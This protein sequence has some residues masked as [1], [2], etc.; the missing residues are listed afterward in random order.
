M[1]KIFVAMMAIVAM[2]G[3]MFLAPST[4]PVA[5]VAYAEGNATNIESSTEAGGYTKVE[6]YEDGDTIPAREEHVIQL[7]FKEGGSF[8]DHSVTIY[9]ET[10]AERSEAYITY[11][12][13]TLFG[14][15]AD[16]SA[17][18]E[19]VTAKVIA[20]E[21]VNSIPEE[22]AVKVETVKTQI[23]AENEAV[24]EST[25]FGWVNPVKIFE[26][27]NFEENADFFEKTFAWLEYV[28]RIAVYVGLVLILKNVIV[29]IDKLL[30]IIFR[31]FK[32][33]W[34]FAHKITEREEAIQKF[35]KNTKDY[36]DK[37]RFTPEGSIAPTDLSVYPR[38]IVKWYKELELTLEEADELKTKKRFGKKVYQD[39][40]EF[41]EMYSALMKENKK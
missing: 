20:H 6:V 7:V 12:G 32:R 3:T 1:K 19:E 22:Y 4:S 34:C 18:K 24:E 40:I 23:A 41:C 38:Q 11:Y 17:W 10:V 37:R 28:A 9:P 21:G 15:D 26:G 36:L 33:I 16:Y 30:Q 13:S 31:F 25:F 8:R 29:I 14:P 5:F 39:W 2:L 27:V 35:V